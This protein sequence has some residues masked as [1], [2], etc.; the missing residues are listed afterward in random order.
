MGVSFLTFGV[1]FLTL[2]GTNSY[3]RGLIFLRLGVKD[4][5]VWGLVFLRLQVNLLTFRG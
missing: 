4:F 1:K 5:Y 2:R 3:V